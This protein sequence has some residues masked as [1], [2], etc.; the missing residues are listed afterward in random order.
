MS[1][2]TIMHSSASIAELDDACWQKNVYSRFDATLRSSHLLFPCPFGVAGHQSGHIRFGFCDAASAPV[3]A[4]YLNLF[5]PKCREFGEFTSLVIFEK[6]AEVQSMEH[7]H[8]KFWN[9]LDDLSALDSSPWPTAIPREIDHK[10]WEFCFL[11]EPIFVLCATPCHVL[12]ESRRASGFTMTFQ[13]RWVFD[14]VLDT[15]KSA[16]KV[17]SAVKER[18]DKFDLVEKS[19]F[20]GK[21]GRDRPGSQS[22]F[23]LR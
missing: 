18:L 1:N 13:P 12:R 6:P 11:G 22:V 15:P 19:P 17:F 14:R 10:H 7:Y 9:I 20:L 5:I 16:A 8:R 2:S 21:Y 23:H 3:I 4:E